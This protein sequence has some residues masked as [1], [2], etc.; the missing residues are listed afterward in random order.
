MLHTD[1]L[2]D[3]QG[4]PIMQLKPLVVILALL[5]LPMWAACLGGLWWLLTLLH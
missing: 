1:E 5:S 2:R 4:T 3:E